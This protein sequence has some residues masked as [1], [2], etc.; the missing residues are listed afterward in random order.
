MATLE[1]FVGIR[2]CFRDVL[3]RE[4]ANGVPWR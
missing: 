4:A 2:A 3:R 1:Q